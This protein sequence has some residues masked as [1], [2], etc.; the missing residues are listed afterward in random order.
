MNPTLYLLVIASVAISVYYVM[1]EAWE[2]DAFGY[3]RLGSGPNEAGSIRQKKL[4]YCYYDIDNFKLIAFH[5][6]CWCEFV[7]LP[8]DKY[9]P[10]SK[11][12]QDYWNQQAPHL[13]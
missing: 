9:I 7:T 2:F 8:S 3:R 13:A 4:G 1:R 5:R 6:G 10:L 12:E 11:E